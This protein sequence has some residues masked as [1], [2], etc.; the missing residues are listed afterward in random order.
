MPGKLTR[1][2][3]T[4]KKQDSQKLI[5]SKKNSKEDGDERWVSTTK[6]PMINSDW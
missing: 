3:K 6:M 1:M 2:N 4:F 5:I